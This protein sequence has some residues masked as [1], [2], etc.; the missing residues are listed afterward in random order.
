MADSRHAR[1]TRLSKRR[2]VYV[3]AHHGSGMGDRDCRQTKHFD[4][5]YKFF[6]TFETPQNTRWTAVSSWFFVNPHY[7]E[8]TTSASEI[9][10]DLLYFWW[11]VPTSHRNLQ[12]DSPFPFFAIA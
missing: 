2:G 12:T 10:P 11:S 4:I 5:N 9:G 8:L 1:V 6:E 3:H 7:L